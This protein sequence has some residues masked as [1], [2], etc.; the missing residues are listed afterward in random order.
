MEPITR[1]QALAAGISPRTL[2]GPRYRRL[3]RGVYLHAGQRP[4]LTHWVAAARLVLP[5][6]ARVTG[7]TALRLR[8]LDVGQDFPLDFVTSFRERNRHAG[9]RVA[10]R[11]DLEPGGGVATPIEAFVEVC[12]RSDLLDAVQVGDRMLH[13]RM[14]AF[15]DFTPLQL[16]PLARVANAAK[17]VRKG[18]ES[19]KETHLRLLNVL[20]GLPEPE[21][22]V[23]IT[24]DGRWIGRVLSLIH[25]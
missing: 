14:V 17:L 2:A 12:R 3:Y 16:H 1:Q 7:L 8:G 4:D 6:D 22:Q 24:V 9:T 25:I 15:E 18:S 13:R 11:C 10:A 21:L 19:V 20:A 23:T 5:P